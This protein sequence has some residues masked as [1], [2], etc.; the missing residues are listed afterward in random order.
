MAFLHFF[1]QRA[2]FQ[3]I[4]VGLGGRLD[5]TNL[6]QPQVCVL[7]SISLDHTSILGSTVERIARDKSGIIKPGAVAVASP[8]EPGVMAVLEETCQAQGVKLISVGRECEWTLESHDLEG[9][10]FTVATPWGEFH[11]RTPLLGGH[12][13]ENSTTALAAIHALQELGFDVAVDS[14]SR[15]F[16]TLHW[17][18]RMEVLSRTPLV[19]ADGAHT[20]YSAAKLREALYQYLSFR[21]LI[22]VVGLSADKDVSGIVRELAQGAHMAVVT[23][24]RHPRAVAT[25]L[26]ASEFRAAGVEA[27]EVEGVGAAVSY[28]L[29]QAS[30]G[31]LVVA[32]GSLFVAAE[33][34][35]MMLGILPE[36]YPS[37][38]PGTPVL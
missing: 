14:I 1:Q 33:A 10:S 29:D 19:V 21:R 35:E 3:V 18:A 25:S 37:L 16:R 12:Q 5:S 20:P 26:M 38:Q 7:T 24:S 32:T 22:Y 4:E 34:R 31:D 28:A 8:Q 6:V 36:I 2:G 23:R 11:L 13:L 17:P 9:Q 15:G 27:R 30:E